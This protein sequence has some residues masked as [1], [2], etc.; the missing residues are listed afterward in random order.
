MSSSFLKGI[1][2]W[3]QT[4]TLSVIFFQLFEDHLAPIVLIATPGVSLTIAPSKVNSSHSQLIFF[5]ACFVFCSF[6]TMHLG[7]DFF[8]LIQFGMYD[9]LNP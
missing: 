5:S 4:P 3:V 1:F 2:H 9:F 6:T 8:L 7:V